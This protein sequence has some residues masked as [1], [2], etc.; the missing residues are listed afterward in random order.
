MTRLLERRLLLPVFVV[1]LALMTFVVL[2]PDGE[3][4]GGT[5]DLAV[6]V[7]HAIGFPR[8]TEWHLEKALNVALFLPLGGLGVL[9]WRHRPWWLWAPIGA[10]LSGLYEAVQGLFLPN[11]VA[12]GW[13]VVTNTAGSV[14]GAAVAAV[15]LHEVRLQRRPETSRRSLLP[16]PLLAL[17]AGGVAL[18]MVG[19]VLGPTSEL[20]SQ[21][22]YAVADRIRAWGGPN[23][24]A[25]YDTWEKLL[26]VALFVPIAAVAALIRPG[27]SLLRFVL[28]GFAGS[29]AIELTQGVLLPGR[30]ASFADL[31]TNTAGALI[32]AAAVKVCVAAYDRVRAL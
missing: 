12:D 32:G 26:N 10:A 24:L 28:L 25:D 31:A 2:Q 14:A 6:R 27:W 18:A 1:Y 23:I 15:V 11:R 7:L 21:A 4:S 30:D 29:L 19:L 5:I 9:L 17:I 20:P 3:T 13:D 16:P 22:V 8:F